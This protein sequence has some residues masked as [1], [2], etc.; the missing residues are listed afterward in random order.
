VTTAKD[1]ESAL[2]HRSHPIPDRRRVDRLL[3]AEKDEGDDDR[4]TEQ[5]AESYAQ[6]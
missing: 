6:R 2:S 3:T 5:D 1:L 4:D